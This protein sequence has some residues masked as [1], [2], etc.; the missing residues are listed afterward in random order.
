MSRDPALLDECRALQRAVGPFPTLA[1]L[2]ASPEWKTLGPR[3]RSLLGSVH[4]HDPPAIP[5]PVARSVVRAVHWNVEHGNWYDQVERALLQHPDLADAD[6]LHFNEIDLGMARA[7]NRDVTADLCRTL[8]RYGVWAPMFLETTLGRDDDS[9]TAAGRDNEESLFGLAILSRWPFGEVRVVELP[10]PEAVQ[11][12]LERMVGRHVALVAEVLRPGAP[13]VAVTAH[14]EVHRTR[15][16]RANQIRALLAG[17]AEERRPIILSGDFNTHTFDR[18]L[19][20]SALHAGLVLFMS[21]G[22]T[23]SRRFLHPD[24]GAHREP[25]F[26]LLQA[27]GFA[28]APYVD[29][30]RSLQLRFDRVDEA[31]AWDW[32]ARLMSP[33]V[34]WAVGRGTLRLDWFAGRGWRS[35]GALPATRGR[36]I[37]GLDGPGCASDH[38]PIVA[39]F[40]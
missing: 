25:L 4:R 30:Q 16:H 35:A 33:L 22:G 17:L 21:P 9:T 34:R 36:T 39:E 26:D 20:H 18:G 31:R 8:G 3:F 23:L 27:G 5:S 28:W 1:A 38:A 37:S 32:L 14:L 19:W 7:G 2:H 11:F 12:D 10:S 15:Q 24:E 13:F 6:L 40:E 29:Y